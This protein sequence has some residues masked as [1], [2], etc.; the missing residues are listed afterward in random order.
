MV[1][2]FTHHVTVAHGQGIEN[3]V[4]NVAVEKSIDGN[5][6]G[7]I[8]E[9]DDPAGSAGTAIFGDSTLC[10]IAQLMRFRRSR[11]II[12]IAGRRLRAARGE[13]K[14]GRPGGE[15]RVAIGAVIVELLIGGN[16]MAA[17]EGEGV[18]KSFFCTGRVELYG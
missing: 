2:D 16:P 12:C 8:A 5:L 17:I 11:H 14:N 10:V 15:L 3:T 6:A 7:W 4:G 1:D 13:R 18:D 9:I